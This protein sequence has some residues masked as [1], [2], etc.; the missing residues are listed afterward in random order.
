MSPLLVAVLVAAVLTGGGLTAAAITLGTPTAFARVYLDALAGGDIR[1][2][3]AM[4][5]I[6]TSAADARSLERVGAAE[7]R[8]DRIDDRVVNEVHH[9]TVTWTGGGTTSETELLVR[10]DG[11][12]WRFSATPLVSA[13]VHAAPARRVLIG[14]ASLPTSANGSAAEVVLAPGAYAVRAADTADISDP[15][16][17]V[18]Q[19]AGG[20]AD[21]SVSVAASPALESAAA[22]AL[23]RILSACANAQVLQPTG[24]PFGYQLTDR[25]VG[26]PEWRIITQP[27]TQLVPGATAGE[28]LLRVADGSAG[29]SLQAQR[30]SDGGVH[31]VADT[32]DIAGDWPLTVSAAGVVSIGELRQ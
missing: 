10:G 27:H 11:L 25:L 17:L 20:T 24:C 4:P 26:V 7:L 30:L 28:W 21:A 13:T 1:G 9:L 23:G 31:A 32:T 19:T 6:R 5:G 29:V 3:L 12:G 22:G 16:Q 2:A 8:I 18:A 15:A 14:A